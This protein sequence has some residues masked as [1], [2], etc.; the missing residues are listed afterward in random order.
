MSKS[1]SN[2]LTPRSDDIWQT[3]CRLAN[4][5]R[6]YSS[7]STPGKGY[8]TN[9]PDFQAKLQSKLASRI[10]SKLA[11]RASSEATS[12]IHSSGSSQ[13]ASRIHSSG[14]SQEASR[15]HSQVA[16]TYHTPRNQSGVCTP[17]QTKKERLQPIYEKDETYSEP[18][19]PVNLQ[20]V[21]N[22]PR[23]DPKILEMEHKQMLLNYRDDCPTPA[24]RSKPSQHQAQMKPDSFTFSSPSSNKPHHPSVRFAYT[25][26]EQS[27]LLEAPVKPGYNMGFVGKHGQLS[28]S[29]N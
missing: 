26:G 14:S 1:N 2:L 28:F 11:S 22:K 21:L 5:Q 18:I 4:S 13:E 10:A 7:C 12:R 29:Y 8:K 3:S 17:L 16:T 20:P 27:M 9:D 15:I 19:S 25:D 6:V 24:R 23:I